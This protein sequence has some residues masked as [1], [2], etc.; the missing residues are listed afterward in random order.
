[1]RLEARRADSLDEYEYRMT[2]DTDARRRL[3]K[4]WSRAWG[5]AKNRELERNRRAGVIRAQEERQQ[6]VERAVAALPPLGPEQR[7]DLARIFT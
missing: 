1:M 5:I 3:L 4:K 2:A 6:W 7:A